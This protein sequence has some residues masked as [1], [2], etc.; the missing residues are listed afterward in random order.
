[1]EEKKSTVERYVEFLLRNRVWLLILLA[2]ITGFFCYRI[3]HLKIATDFFSLYPPRHPYI[4]L[5]NE[6]R[7]MF[8]S[9]NVIVCAVEVKQG[10]IYNWDT[11]DKI[12]RITKALPTIKGCNASQCLSFCELADG[13]P[14]IRQR[15]ENKQNSDC[16]C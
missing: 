8:G 14:E 15:I 12:T 4:K 11:L 7:K 6:Y 10:D 9:A 1:M 13:S 16:F 2:L 5:Y 3:Y